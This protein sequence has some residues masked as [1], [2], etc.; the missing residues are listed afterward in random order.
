MLESRK[1]HKR[2]DAKDIANA[3][4][5]AISQPEH[6]DFNEIIVRPTGQK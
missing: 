6:V 5:Y 4:L 3:I 2:L 1:I